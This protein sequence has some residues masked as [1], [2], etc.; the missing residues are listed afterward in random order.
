MGVTPWTKIP[1]PEPTDAVAKGAANMKAMAQA[2][3]G[4]FG[5]FG[6][7]SGSSVSGRGSQMG[8]RGTV[9]TWRG[10]Q[11]TNQYGQ[12]S[13]PTVSGTAGWAY[14]EAHAWSA[15]QNGGLIYLVLDSANS[16][17]ASAVFYVYQQGNNTIMANYAATFT[18]VIHGWLPITVVP[19][20]P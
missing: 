6:M 20:V 16:S 18:A 5:S 1:Y 15:I 12:I 14:A 13:I 3:E 11:T 19:P 8:D 4:A 9:V 7:A 2:T 17:A 10:T